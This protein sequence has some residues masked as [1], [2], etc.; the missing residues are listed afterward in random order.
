MSESFATVN[1]MT[2]L[3][4]ELTPEEEERADALLPLISDALKYEASKVNKDLD[5]MAADNEAYANVLK[6]VTVDI[7]SRVL[8]QNTTGEAMTQESQAARV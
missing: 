8:R 3:W 4:R 7:C 5:R 6:L 1:D 2:S